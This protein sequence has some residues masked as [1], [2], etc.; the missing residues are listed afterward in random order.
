MLRTNVAVV[1]CGPYGLSAGAHLSR[2]PNVHVRVFGEPM[3]FWK[4]N[5]PE[6]ML[7]RSSWE[8]SHIADPREA[9]TLDAFCAD[10][11]TPRQLP[12][13]L[14]TFIE[15]GAWYQRRAVPEVDRRIVRRVDRVADGF[16]LSFDEGSP[17]KADRVVLATGIAAFA[18]RPLQFRALSTEVAPHASKFKRPSAYAGKRVA[19]IGCGQSAL[20]CAALLQESGARVEIIMRRPHVHWLGWKEKLQRLGAFSRVLFSPADVGPAGVSR[21]VAAPEWFT[22]LPRRMQDRLRK[23]CLRPAGASWLVERLRAVPITARRSVLYAV[24]RAHSIR[25]T[26]DDYSTRIV[27][28][29]LL[30]TGYQMDVQ[31]LSCLASAITARLQTVQGFPVLNRHFESSVP[32][33]HFIGAPAA[34]SFGPLLHFV[35]GTRFCAAT[36]ADFIAREDWRAGQKAA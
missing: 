13:P 12:V 9:L 32:G 28:F 33:L 22:R 29:V 16:Q 10:S 30:G 14:S 23:T 31:Q 7:L 1:G 36:L 2:I 17:V 25:L 35:S 26:L 21:L 4:D 8:A 19:V 15:Y 18:Y 20:E 3:S 6:G 27:D 5:M 11:K 34:W 24:P